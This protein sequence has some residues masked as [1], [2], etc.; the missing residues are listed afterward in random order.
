MPGH[1]AISV[2]NDFSA[3]Q[4]AVTNRAADDEITGGID[5]VLRVFESQFA[6]KT[7]LMISSMTAS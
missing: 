3:G 4:S 5:K 7:G 2:N 1:A 6:G